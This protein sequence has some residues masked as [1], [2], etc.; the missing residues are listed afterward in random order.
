MTMAN[1]H[2]RQSRVPPPAPG[3]AIVVELRLGDDL[4][5][6]LKALAR[7]IPAA[8]APQPPPAPRTL[9]APDWS[10]VVWQGTRYIL[11]PKQR[12][13]IA[14][15]WRAWEDGTGF[16]SH[17]YLLEKA[18]T[19]QQKMYYL[20]RGSPAWGALIVPGEPHGGPV[21]SYCLAPASS[22]LAAP[23]PVL[24]L[25]NMVDQPAHAPDFSSVQWAGR[26]Y[27]LTPKQRRAVALLWNAWEEGKRFV[28]E[29]R[30][31]NGADSDQPKL[32]HL[33]KGSDAWGTLVVPGDL[34]GGDFATFCL[35]PLD[36]PD[37]AY[38][39]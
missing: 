39:R 12:L 34:H 35:A 7:L 27:H 1:G 30:L 8:A 6:A 10:S 16:L 20:F 21:D 36:T 17:A 11:T 22:E 26:V 19:D 4:A 14:E 13:V 23:P 15:L 2:T 32:S 5:A 29:V 9:H 37:P 3:Q 31:L 18:E 33:F 28:S 38:G 24:P 25:V